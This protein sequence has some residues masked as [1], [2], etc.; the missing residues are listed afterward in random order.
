MFKFLKLA[1]AV[2]TVLVVVTAI[3]QAVISAV[4][5]FCQAEAVVF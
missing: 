4:E 5:P 1:K 2:L 3:L